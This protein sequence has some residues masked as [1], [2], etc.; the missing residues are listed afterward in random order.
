MKA[1]WK[2]LCHDKRSR[3]T[4]QKVAKYT[5][6]CSALHNLCIK[7]KVPNYE[8]VRQTNIDEATVNFDTETDRQI[9]KIGKQIRDNIKNS[10]FPN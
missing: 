2:I 8:D 4:P 3:Y 6:V 7:F 5:N 10:L 1:R 9:T